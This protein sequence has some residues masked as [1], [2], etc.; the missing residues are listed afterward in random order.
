MTVI[1]ALFQRPTATGPAPAEGD[2]TFV[3]TRRRTAGGTTIATVLPAPFV[4]VANAQGEATFT[5][6]PSTASWVWKAVERFANLPPVV[7]YLVVPDSLVPV[8]YGSLA[9]VDPATLL[10]PN[11]PDPVWYAYVDQL[12]AEAALAKTSASAS[13]TSAETAQ[14]AA[15]GSQSSAAGSAATAT[16]KAGEAAGSATAAAGSASTA[17][18][19]A[20]EA[21]TSATAAAG[22]ATA[23]QTARTG[24]ETARTGAETA[25]TGAE[26]A[27]TGAETAKTGA[28][29]ART[30]AETAKTAAETARTQAIAHATGFSMGIVTTGAPGSQAS[31]AINGTAPALKLD[32]NIPRGDTGA[33]PNISVGTVTTGNAP[34][35]TEGPQGLTGPQGIQ[36]N[37]GDLVATAGPA[38][39]SGA[40]TLD[41]AAYPST[42]SWTLT[43]NVTLTLPTPAADKSGTI[44]LVL[45]QDA[46]GGRTITWP[47][48][49]KWPEAIAQ[50]PASG[51]TTVSIIHLLWTGTQW[52]GMVGGKS[53]A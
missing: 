11:A 46:T 6:E 24:A 37:P 40:I 2:V 52:L 32:L 47:A 20:G 35:V 14:A 27:R 33:T 41:A 49:V 7:R 22:S 18:T 12:R 26:T 48:A 8:S 36:G 21:A 38:N 45:T 31:A 25:R 39:V 9:E 16:T 19:K 28:E 50:Q 17:S 53:F 43:G 3:P 23:A 1:N 15:S 5:L 42:R 51:A 10:A 44:T 13:K 4:A 30:G 29:T 34:Q